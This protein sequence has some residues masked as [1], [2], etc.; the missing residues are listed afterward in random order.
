MFKYLLGRISKYADGFLTTSVPLSPLILLIFILFFSCNTSHKESEIEQWKNEILETELSFAKMLKKEGVAKAFL[1]F[2]A[3][4][5][6]LMRNDSLIIGKTAIKKMYTLNLSLSD[7]VSLTWK[8]DFVDVAAS[9]ELG[10]TYGKYVYTVTDSLGNTN[11]AEGIFHTV[12]KRQKEGI[13][14]FVWD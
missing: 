1:F 2:A 3:E 4:D 5:A 8:A 6:V 9:G 14:K 7:D 11:T 10:Y 12:W 13:W